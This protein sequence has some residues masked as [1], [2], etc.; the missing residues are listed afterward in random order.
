[1]EMKAARCR[2]ARLL[3]WSRY[4]PLAHS[5]G[6][7]ARYFLSLARSNAKAIAPPG[8]GSTRAGARFGSGGRRSRGL[9]AASAFASGRVS[10]ERNPVP[11]ALSRRMVKEI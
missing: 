2:I 9:R 5:A 3:D 4:Q 6:N 11:G 1:M 7:A 10:L 8:F